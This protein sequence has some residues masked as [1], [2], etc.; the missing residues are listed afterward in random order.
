VSGKVTKSWPTSDGLYTTVSAAE[1]IK[2]LFGE[3][4]DS[5][6]PSEPCVR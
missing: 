5:R 4:A 1:L 3:W 6:G 2:M